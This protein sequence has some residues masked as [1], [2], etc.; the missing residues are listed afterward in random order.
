M[1]FTNKGHIAANGALALQA[2]RARAAEWDIPAI[3]RG[4][5][6]HFS[7]WNSEAVLHAQGDGLVVKLTAPEERLL[8]TL[9]GSLTELFD[10]QGMR[11]VWQDVDEGALA[12]GLSLMRVMSVTRR[13]P[14]FLR[15]R[16]QGHDAARLGKGSLHFRLLLPPKDRAPRW[17]RIAAS[18]RTVWPEGEDAMHRPVY[19]TAAQD[20]DWLDFDIFRHAGSPTSDWAESNPAGQIVGV[21]GPG[22]GW[23]PEGSPLYLFGDQT[24]LPA[25]CRMLSLAGGDV[26][27]FV[28]AAE[29]DLCELAGDR[30]V[31]VVSDLVAALEATETPGGAHVWFAGHADAARAARARLTARGFSKRDFT[32]AAY[33]S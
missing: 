4:R 25:I 10:E 16:L 7:V 19:T 18:G 14:G 17:P 6:L 32:A 31:T 15:V 13:S 22:G 9:Q 8:K 5:D 3:E 29:C 30:R 27:A 21:M 12:P 26:R 24:A 28:C 1:T 20:A 2:V 11:I 23:C 33:W